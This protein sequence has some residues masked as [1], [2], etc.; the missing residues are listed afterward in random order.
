MLTPLQITG[1]LL[2]GA[3]ILVVAIETYPTRERAT[4]N[5][6]QITTACHALHA[7]DPATT[8]DCTGRRVLFERE[9][10]DACLDLSL[11]TSLDTRASVE[12]HTNCLARV[13]RHT[14]G[15]RRV[16]GRI[17]AWVQRTFPDPQEQPW[18][19]PAGR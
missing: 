11:D 8:A 9:L 6:E 14:Q 17:S 5:R 15:W 2:L 19:Y 12:A 4:S 13:T 16:P 1:L 10:L 3:A 18:A 7:P